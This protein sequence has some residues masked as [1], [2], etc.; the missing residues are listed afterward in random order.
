MLMIGPFS[1]VTGSGTLFKSKAWE[2]AGFPVIKEIKPPG[3]LI[4]KSKDS[5]SKNGGIQALLYG[6]GIKA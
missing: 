5:K 2:K 4:A 3:R 1:P 6:H